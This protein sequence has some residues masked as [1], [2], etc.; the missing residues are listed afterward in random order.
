MTKAT[1]K[2]PAKA[3]KKAA[4]ATTAKLP[5]AADVIKKLVEKNTEAHTRE[6]LGR[7]AYSCQS[8]KLDV[9]K[10][11][12]LKK[13]DPTYGITTMKVLRL[14]KDGQAFVVQRNGTLKAVTHT[15][16]PAFAFPSTP[17]SEGKKK[18]TKKK[19][20]LSSVLPNSAAKKVT[21]IRF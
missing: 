17:K 2:T 21:P 11:G 4:K 7:L 10:V 14:E 19:S 3:V 15:M 13:N 6:T 5:S 16:V 1:T 18:P 20:G 9:L 8:A 12:E